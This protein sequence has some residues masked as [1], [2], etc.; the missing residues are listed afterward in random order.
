MDSFQ[1]RAFIF[2]GCASMLKSSLVVV[3]IVV[4]VVRF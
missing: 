2:S 3:V 4:I 1:L